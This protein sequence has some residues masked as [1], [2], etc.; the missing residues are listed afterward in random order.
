[1]EF[2]LNTRFRPR[3]N[4]TRSPKACLT[5]RPR[6]VP[7]QWWLHRGAG[8][9][10]DTQEQAAL[11]FHCLNLSFHP[12]CGAVSS[13]TSHFML[14]V[15]ISPLVTAALHPQWDWMRQWWKRLS[16]SL[17]QVRFP[18]AFAMY[19]WPY[20]NCSAVYS[21][22]LPVNQWICQWVYGFPSQA[23]PTFFFF[24]NHLQCL[25]AS[26][27]RKAEPDFTRLSLLLLGLPC[28]EL[29]TQKLWAETALLLEN[30]TDHTA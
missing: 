6:T 26:H 21:W 19:T 24:F 18:S 17:T 16:K 22:L 1:M 9:G 11:P 4:A 12:R 14:G 23:P 15:S 8:G 5:W 30:K 2:L 20:L 25:P 13:L 10:L 29:S 28:C 7:P 27:Y 3:S